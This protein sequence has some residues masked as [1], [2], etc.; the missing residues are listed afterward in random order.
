LDVQYDSGPSLSAILADAFGCGKS[1]EVLPLFQVILND[2]RTLKP[3]AVVIRYGRSKPFL[4]VVPNNLVRQ[5][6]K[7]I[8][9]H[10]PELVSDIYYTGYANKARSENL[11]IFPQRNFGLG[12]NHE[13]FKSKEEDAAAWNDAD[14]ELSL[15][16]ILNDFI[17]QG[18]DIHRRHRNGDTA[19]AQRKCIQKLGRSRFELDR[20]GIMYII[21]NQYSSSALISDLCD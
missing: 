9:K 4:I 15:L 2:R 11:K 13:I 6:V 3:R 5:W 20:Q 1:I 10:T 8:G 16:G 14:D 7:E 12:R 18:R 19:L 17:E 21:I